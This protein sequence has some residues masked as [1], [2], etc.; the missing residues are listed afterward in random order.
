MELFTYE[1]NSDR[2]AVIEAGGLRGVSEQ[3]RCREF[4]QREIWPKFVS[5][6]LFCHALD[7]SVP[8]H[9]S[10]MMKRWSPTD[11]TRAEKQSPN[12]GTR[13]EELQCKEHRQRI[14]PKFAHSWHRRLSIRHVSGRLAGGRTRTGA[15]SWGTQY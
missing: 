9:S 15:A 5:S 14:W 3:R 1:W 7:I 4:R 11:G 10:L 2:G 12:Q 8:Q 13:E 6:L